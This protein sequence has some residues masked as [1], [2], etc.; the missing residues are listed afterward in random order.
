MM[1]PFLTQGVTYLI[2]KGQDTRDP[3]NYRPITCLPTL[4]K[5]I[6]SIVAR[7]IHQHCERYEILAEEQKGCRK[8][9]QGCKEQLTID[10]VVVEQAC[11]GRRNL[12][13][14]YIDYKKAFDTVPH[15]WLF[16]VLTVYKIHPTITEFLKQVA[17]TWRTVLKIKTYNRHVNT[18]PIPIKR[19]IF[20]GDALSPLWF[21][22]ALNPL[23]HLLNSSPCGFNIR[24]RN[25]AQYK[26]THLLYMDDL[27]LY[28]S[29][30]VHLQELLNLTHTFSRDIQM[31][32]GLDKCRTQT[33]TRGLHAEESIQLRDNVV[34]SALREGETY[35]YLGCQQS[36]R[37]QHKQIKQHLTDEFTTRLKAI[38]RT[39]LDSQ[40]LVK[41]VNT[42]AIPV[43]TYSFGVIHWTQTELHSLQTRINTTLTL[44]RKH[45]PK[46]AIERL[47]LP[48]R[49]GG[50]GLI[51]ITNLHNKQIDNLRMYFQQKKETSAIHKSIN[52]A[53]KYSPLHLTMAE[54]DLTKTTEEDKILAWKQK[55]L[56][57][58]YPNELDQLHVD[59]EASYAWL[60]RSG[61]HP[62]TEGFIIAIQDQVIGTRNY[63]KYILKDPAVHD[64]SCRRCHEMPETVQHVIAACKT[65]AQTDYKHRHDQVASIIHQ[66]LAR[67]CGLTKETVPYYKYSPTVILENDGF[68]MYW[69]RTIITDKT[70]HH[71]RPDIT[72]IHKRNKVTYLID[73][74]VPNTHNLQ[75]THTAKIAKYADLSI[76]LKD[77]WKMDSVVTV[78]IVL[79]ATGVIPKTLHKSIATLELPPSTFIELQKAAILNTCHVM[80]KFLDSNIVGVAQ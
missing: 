15:S 63:R 8:S 57:G 74:A 60:T 54:L 40:N 5:I 11:H 58:R 69:D 26:L 7:K 21:C 4:Y 22:L 50:R 29:N 25:A 37:I 24:H 53:D 42:Y 39:H 75:A 16:R 27:K 19:G 66:K 34:I 17:S 36:R 48:R 76:E 68:R 70:V 80:R 59:K 23:S 51:D 44:Y 31:N 3:A 47:T 41:A 28:A 38:L 62:E 71:N 33:I 2:P 13:A 79:S 43:L 55:V 45:H 72:L 61:L 18:E 56:H 77:Q 52:L 6:T 10:S 35:R 12:N 30:K 9:S 1:P 67:Q 64:D 65:L 49:M 14:A 32:F 73:I 78:P 20:Q 46:S